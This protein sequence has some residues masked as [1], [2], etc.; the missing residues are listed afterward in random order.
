MRRTTKKRAVRIIIL[1]AALVLG[2]FFLPFLT[3]FFLICGLVDV[4]RNTRRDAMVFR[5]YFTGNGI[6]TW[7]LSPFNL[8]IDLFCH[9][10][11]GIYEID[12]LP[13]EW[14]AEVLSVLEV[15]HTQKNDILAD[16]DH[17][18]D[19]TRRG[20]FVYEWY[21]KRKRHPVAALER[22][23]KYIKTIAVTVF[24][25]WETTSFHFGP[26][27]LTLRAL[28][29][30]TPTDSEGVYAQCGSH[31]HLWRDGSLYIFDD[32]LIHRSVNGE[33]ARSYVVFID[34]MRPTAFPGL[35]NRL[36]AAVSVLVGPSN[37][38]FYKNW[39][40]FEPRRRTASLL[41]PWASIPASKGRTPE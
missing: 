13:A 22:D 6:V 5:R 14:R 20:M 24:S 41:V 37:R 11:R 40:M 1:G 29:N 15:F 21:G 4:L 3:A 2:F 30:L 7:L 10:N 31:K 34:L 25:G 35:L 27:R 39:R 23:Y 38:M 16:L 36:I 9:K 26:L 28:Y 17:S 12:D 32:T 19:G 33:H 18:F 8:C